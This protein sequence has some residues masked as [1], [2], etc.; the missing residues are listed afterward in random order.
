MFIC[1]DFVVWGTTERRKWRNPHWETPSHGK[2][3]TGRPA[4]PPEA[5]PPGSSWSPR[6][7][8]RALQPAAEKRF[9]VSFYSRDTIFRAL[10]RVEAHSRD[11]CLVC[12]TVATKLNPDSFSRLGD[13]KSNILHIVASLPSCLT[14]LADTF[15]YM[16]ERLP[17]AKSFEN[18][19]TAQGEPIVFNQTASATRPN[20][21]AKG[22]HTVVFAWLSSFFGAPHLG[23]F[24]Y[25]YC[26]SFYCNFILTENKIK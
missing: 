18:V 14:E 4:N 22:D 23:E 5:K 19:L 6:P 16:R 26:N 2:N 8:A 20:Q 11:I 25:W 7:P 10:V 15:L 21:S 13:T 1:C 12:C 9:E 24:I 3:Q 17:H